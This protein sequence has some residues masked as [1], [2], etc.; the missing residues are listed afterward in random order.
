MSNNSARL[1]AIRAIA[2]AA[3]VES[4]FDYKNSPTSEVW[5]DNVFDLNSM[6]ER[7]PK[8]VYKSLK[9]TIEQGGKL[10]LQV[11]DVV[12]EA[13]KTWAIEKGA[14]HYA[15]VFYP[16]TGLTAEKHD[17][18]FDPDGQG[19]TISNFQGEQLVQG[20]PDGSSFPS[21]GVRQTF[22]ARGYTIWDVTS[23]AY[24]MEN[25]NG[26]TLCIPTAFISWTG[27]ALDKKTPVLR[28]MQALNTQAQRV[29]K[30]FGNDGAMV[31]STAGPEQE[32]FLID[33]NFYY[34]RPDLMAA[35]RTLFGAAAPKGQEFDDHYFGVIPQRVL[36]IMFEVER[37][38]FKLGIP[39]KTRH[40]E[41]APGQYEIAPVFEFGNVATD[42]QQQIMVALKRVAEKYGMICLTHE[43]PFAGLNGSG[44]HLNFSLGSAKA[45]NL[46]DPGDTPADNAQF[47][48]MCA[49]MIQATH[50]WAKLLRASV[51]SAS[52]DHRLGANEA[53]PAIISIFLGTELT[54]VFESIAKGAP[55]SA[56]KGELS[57]GVDVIPP[58]PKHSGDR[59]RTSPMA[60]TGNRFEFRAVGSS[61]SLGM[62][63]T[64]LNTIMAESLSEFAE[65]L[66]K[67]DPGSPAA[68]GAVVADIV[69]DVWNSCS[70]A[71]FNG[72]GYSE[73]WHHEAERRGLPNL[74]TAAD[75]LPV[76][77]SKEVVNLF[78][79]FGVLNEKEVLSRYEVYAEQYVG[80][81]NVESNLVVE[82]VRTMIFPAAVRYQSELAA[83]LANLKAVGIEPDH[84]TIEKVTALIRD[85]QDGVTDLAD[86]K[87]KEG[88]SHD[89]EKHGLFVKNKVLPR[90]AAIR[91]V[92]DEL[93]GYVSD[94]LWPLPTYQEMLFVK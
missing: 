83:S 42:H 88:E 80:S 25:P 41:V 36:A 86:L 30:F 43:K 14:T 60:F 31:S 27:E 76:Y 24:I 79:K 92:V 65:K 21:G 22:E 66:E 85:L 39:A 37:E 35:G 55:I 38:L 82:L 7:L 23:P 10:D 71:V 32:Y 68:V 48:V 81:V 61:Q 3:P 59:N 56:E 28:S 91:E 47:L 46:F 52:N 17:S 34:A 89:P 70:Q 20:E 19:G 62:P 2:N 5:G 93:E 69:R 74:R 44:K 9:K 53:P 18:F 26:T 63:L 73:E 54:E 84:K 6:A 45:G 29:L 90:M 1:D 67:A 87:D 13:M 50:R 15:H 12:A 40:N 58:I 78:G 4:T 33:K 75:A 72:D 51:A 11:A 8:S 64:I 57:I 94:D 16:L 77:K 49:A